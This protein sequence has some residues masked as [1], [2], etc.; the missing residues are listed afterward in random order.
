[1]FKLASPAVIARQIYIYSAQPPPPSPPII[2]T[3]WA[4]I[5]QQKN[6]MEYD[7]LNI[8]LIF[9]VNLFRS[10][11]AC[12]CSW[13]PRNN[14]EEKKIRINFVRICVACGRFELQ[15]RYTTESTI[16]CIDLCNGNEII[17]WPFFYS[18]PFSAF[19]TVRCDAMG[20]PY[21]GERHD[22][23][24]W[25][26]IIIIQIERKLGTDCSLSV[27]IRLKI[28]ASVWL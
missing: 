23:T 16:H 19:W 8:K 27:F 17:S 15:C 1:M 14:N 2:R 24:K 18:S 7:T 10:V 13:A 25:F 4:W 9:Y 28:A 26:I 6:T 3:Y 12:S 20:C 11:G 22:D 21:V 5:Q